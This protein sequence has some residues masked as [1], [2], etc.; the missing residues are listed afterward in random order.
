M[1]EAAPSKS[2]TPEQPR[3]ERKWTA[4][5]GYVPKR[6]KQEMEVKAEDEAVVEEPRSERKWTAPEGYVPKR[7]KQEMAVKA[8]DEAV[9]EEPLK[10]ADSEEDSDGLEQ[11]E[12]EKGTG[13]GDVASEPVMQELPLLRDEDSLQPLREGGETAAGEER[14]AEDA[15]MKL[16]KDAEE[17]EEAARASRPRAQEMQEAIGRIKRSFSGIA[18]SGWMDPHV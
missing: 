16:Q 5:E 14:E 6:Q 13:I 18:S 8:E 4:P 1:K 17:A 10:P 11:R 3:S 2:P 7:Q 9:E 12:E 15:V